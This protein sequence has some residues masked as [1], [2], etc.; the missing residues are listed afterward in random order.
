MNWYKF[1]FETKD[2]KVKVRSIAARHLNGAT[3]QLYQE[4]DVEKVIRI[5]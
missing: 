1:K 3:R 5:L 4:Y 2:G